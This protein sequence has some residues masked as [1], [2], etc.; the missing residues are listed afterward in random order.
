MGLGDMTR[1]HGQFVFNSQQPSFI[2][3]SITL[4]SSF[5]VI[6]KKVALYYPGKTT[7]GICCDIVSNGVN[8]P[9]PPLP[10]ADSAGCT[11]R[12]KDTEGYVGFRTSGSTVRNGVTVSVFAKFFGNEATA[13]HAYSVNYRGFGQPELVANPRCPTSLTGGIYGTG[14]E[15]DDFIGPSSSGYRLGNPPFPGTPGSSRA[16]VGDLSGK[17]GL[18]SRNMPSELVYSDGQITLSGPF[19]VM[20]RSVVILG[21]GGAPI[22]CCTIGFGPVGGPDRGFDF[23]DNLGNFTNPNGQEN[24]PE[25]PFAVVDPVGDLSVEAADTWPFWSA[26]RIATLAIGIAA[27]LALVAAIVASMM[28]GGGAAAGDVGDGYVAM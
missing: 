9:A 18:L 13:S 11:W 28:G 2:D 22:G 27:A 17:H 10:R 14:Q 24:A 15:P 16:R 25:D 8:Y 5:N 7:G 12:N 6:G 1:K 23:F 21:V 3:N 26:G 19:S 4:H 20:G